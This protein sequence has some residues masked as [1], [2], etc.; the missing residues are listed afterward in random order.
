[1]AAREHEVVVCEGEWD[2]S[3]AGELAQRVATGLATGASTLILDFRA[4]TFVDAST[5]G[6]L[7]ALACDGSQHGC[8]V[9]VACSAGPVRR[10]FE[11]VHLDDVLPVTPTIEDA[12]ARCAMFHSAVHAEPRRNEV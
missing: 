6:A 1:V 8:A 7:C 4:A 2:I 3:R 12:L 5:I 11:L 10:V 9:A